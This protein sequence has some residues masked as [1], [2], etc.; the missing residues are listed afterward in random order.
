MYEVGSFSYLTQNLASSAPYPFEMSLHFL[1]KLHWFHHKME[2]IV[3]NKGLQH[4]AENVFWNL[5]AEDLKIC[6]RIKSCKQILKYPIFC[7]SKF[8][9]L[10]KKNQRDWL[11]VFQSVKDSDKGIAIISYL[12]PFCSNTFEFYSLVYFLNFNL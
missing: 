12:S 4:L 6:A 10:S 3:N 11:K 7:L 5:E 1:D 8:E 9:H 2:K